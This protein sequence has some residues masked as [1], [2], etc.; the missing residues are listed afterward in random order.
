MGGGGE[1]RGEKKKNEKGEE[2]IGLGGGGVGEE[3]V[4]SWDLT[5][6]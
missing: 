4:G 3:E 5:P 2:V 6:S 1:V